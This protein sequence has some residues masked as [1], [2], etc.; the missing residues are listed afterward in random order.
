MKPFYQPLSKILL[1][2]LLILLIPTGHLAAQACSTSQGDQSTFGSNNVWIG[3]VYSGQN[4][5]NYQGYVTEGSSTSPNFDESF[6]GQTVTYPTNGCS[7][8]TDHFSVRYKLKQ[9]FTANWGDHVY[10]T[11]SYTVTLTGST[12]FVIEYYEDAGDNRITFNIT[13]NCA[14]TGSQSVSGTGNIW[15][16]YIYQGMNFD[17]YKG[18][19]TEGSAA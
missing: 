4:F 9:S 14:G 18:L 2:P 5:D 1:L 10:T 13:Q 15:N 16:G 6:G 8:T 19:V 3:Y 11:T 17:T 12:N 7:I